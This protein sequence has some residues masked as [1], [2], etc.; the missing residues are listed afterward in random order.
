MTQEWPITVMLSALGCPFGCSYC[1]VPPG[2]YQSRP[3]AHTV[4]EIE[5]CV[6]RFGIR[7]I[8]FQDETFTINRERVL[9]LC[10]LIL[11]RGID[12]SWSI[13]ARP[14][15]VDRE[16]LR[17]M[18]KAGLSKINYGIESGDPEMLK[19]MKRA[20]PLDVTR[21]A[22][23]WTKEEGITTLGF[24]I[25]GFPGETEEGLKKTIRFALDLDC[26]FIQVNKMVPQPPS[27][28]YRQLVEETGIDYWRKY[29]LGN[30]DILSRLPGIGSAFSPGELD[31]WQRRFFRAFYYRPSYI[32][33]RLAKLRSPREFSQLARA[34]LSIR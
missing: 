3:P 13:R 18:K 4:D 14:D 28:L 9:E 19:K 24:F 8:L 7:E 26:D 1:D 15:L 12:V 11:A 23:R 16:V 33:K 17:A 6:K 34:A 20:I 30:A 2:R 27:K 21:Q 32:W 22:V 29:T 5:E 10:E 31:D 25:L